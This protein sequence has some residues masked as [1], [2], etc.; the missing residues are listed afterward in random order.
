MTL[1]D[2]VQ[3]PQVTKVSVKK[4]NSPKNPKMSMGTNGNFEFSPQQYFD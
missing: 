2:T 3:M 4:G 1:H